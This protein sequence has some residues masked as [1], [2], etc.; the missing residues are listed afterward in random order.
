[1]RRKQ[2]TL[3]AWLFLAPALIIFLVLIVY[4]IGLSGYASFTKWKYTAG[5]KGMKWY[6]FQNYINIFKDI[7][8]SS[9]IENT[10]L[11]VLITVPISI[12]L[13]LIFAYLLNNKVFLPKTLRLFY[14]I[15]YIA[16]AVAIATL[17]QSWFRTDG[18]INN[19][20]SIFSNDTV[21][22]KW[23]TDKNLCKIPVMVMLVWTSLGY[24]I[25][26]YMGALQNVSSD[27]YEAAEIDGA[28]KTKQFIHIT[29]PMVSQTT[30]YLIIVRMIAVFKVFVSVNVMSMK[31]PARYNT[32]IMVEVYN[33][34]FSK[35]Q[36]GKA[37]A[38]AWI[39]VLIVLFFTAVQ[40]V[41]QK[42][43]VHY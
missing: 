10:F 39:L 40:F 34:A 19:I 42:K 29:F 11:Y 32:S 18:L 7:N 8:F 6:G 43:W 38:E 36:F 12:L 24:L 30:F 4:P 3:T 17:F 1:M 2:D 23:M 21:G 31:N 16:N 15:P 27:L 41:G 5:L 33:T 20:L 13:S 22:L 9:A 28:S 14:F 37:C 25:I 35:M 26:I